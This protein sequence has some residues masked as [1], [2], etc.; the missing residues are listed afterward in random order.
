LRGFGDQLRDARQARG[1]PLEE[2][3]AATRVAVRHL[4][5]LERGDVEA[6]PAG[7]FA[8]GYIEACAGHLGVDPGPIL[9]A[10]RA[11]GRK[12]GLDV[13]ETR[14]RVFEELSHIVK[15]RTAPSPHARSLPGGRTLLTL[16]LVALGLGLGAWLLTRDRATDDQGGTTFTPGAL[17]SKEAAVP[18]GAP[19]P[20]AGPRPASSSEAT[21]PTTGLLEGDG[22][23]VPTHAPKAA[24][25]LAPVRPNPSMRVP[26][27]GV[28]TGVESHRLVGGGD[29]FP[30]GSE[31]VFWTN[32][33]GGEAGNVIRHVWLHE[34]RGIARI[35]LAIGSS[36]WRTFS[37]RPLP[38]GAAGPWVAEARDVDGRLLARQEFVCVSVNPGEPASGGRPPLER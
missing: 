38:P 27:F 10:Y 12:R 6:L 4:E 35:S 24:P 25:P 3:A 14:D 29:R 18:P 20:P 23:T 17:P 11:E 34:G 9:E 16:L 22:G 1:L 8:R 33:V 37:R 32:V 26:D 7:P 28:G 5:A 2:V 15:G 36:H 30:E 31:V 21:R 13:P 19:G